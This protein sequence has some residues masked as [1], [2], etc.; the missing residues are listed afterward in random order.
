M[1]QR[2]LKTLTEICGV[3]P[4]MEHAELP[5]LFGLRL[6]LIRLL[7]ILIFWQRPSRTADVHG[8]L[9]IRMDKELGSTLFPRSRALFG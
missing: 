8:L 7:G 9:L 1:R 3:L 5:S 4:G 2:L 6:L